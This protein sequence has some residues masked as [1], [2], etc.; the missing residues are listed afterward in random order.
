MTGTA[1]LWRG[2]RLVR[3]IFPSP[4]PSVSISTTKGQNCL[5]IIRRLVTPNDIF[6]LLKEA[7]PWPW[8]SASFFFINHLYDD[9]RF[10]VEAGSIKVNSAQL[11][12]AQL[13]ST[14]L[15]STQLC[16]TL[17]NY[18]LLNST[19]LFLT[20]LNSTQLYS[21]QLY[22]TLLR[23]YSTLLERLLNRSR[24]GHRRFR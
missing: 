17:P 10:A 3:I 14:L 8:P 20:L 11:C 15:C 24:S 18:S 2:G 16:S 13:C 4:A 21:T 7:R 5:M 6:V 12:Y 1:A 9:C 22:S 23:L 19:Q